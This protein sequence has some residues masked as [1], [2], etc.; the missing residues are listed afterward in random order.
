M[1]LFTKHSLS[2]HVKSLSAYLP[3]SRLFRAKYR[4]GTELNNLLQGIA[5]ELVRC[6]NSVS[7]LFYEH[8]LYLCTNLIEEWE[9][10]LGI[11]DGIFNGNGPIEERRNHCIV[12][13]TMSVQTEQDFI[14]LGALLGYDDIEIFPLVAKEYLPVPVPFIPWSGVNARFIAV[15]RGTGIL[16]KNPPYNVPFEVGGDSS[17]I[18]NLFDILKP[19]H[20][21][22]IYEDRAK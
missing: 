1:K 18:I 2:Q 13:L 3:N 6:E 11:P 12:K 19:A 17:I 15:V 22:F 10:A 21:L 8:D 5:G 9:R 14:D 16:P 4:K 7:D 20:T